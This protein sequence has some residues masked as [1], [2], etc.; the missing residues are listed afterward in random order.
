MTITPLGDNVLVKPAEES[1]KLGGGLVM[2]E[3]SRPDTPVQG[4]VTA[5]GE[6]VTTVAIGDDIL[7]KKYSPDEFEIEKE[8]VLLI[9]ECEILAKLE[10]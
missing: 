7:F 6:K 10:V 9:Q 2:P 1:S 3:T 8:R 5:I 4:T